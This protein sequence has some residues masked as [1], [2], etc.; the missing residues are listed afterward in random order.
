MSH[1]Q[2]SVKAFE[3][4]THFSELLNRAERG[5]SIAITR[6]GVHVATLV[7]AQKESE[8]KRLAAEQILERRKKIQLEGRG[9]K[10]NEILS[11]RDEGRK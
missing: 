4:K 9:L 2:D 7:P 6:H 5:E 8:R 1:H 11:A 3:A 10:L